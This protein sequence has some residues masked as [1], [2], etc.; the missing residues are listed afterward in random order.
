MSTSI[1]FQTKHHSVI[2]ITNITKI[3]YLFHL[4]RRAIWEFLIHYWLRRTLCLGCRYLNFSQAT[5]NLEDR[6]DESGSMH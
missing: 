3:I 5:E 1:F 4:Q 6:D 2:I